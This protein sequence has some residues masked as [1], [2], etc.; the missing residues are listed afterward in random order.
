LKCP[1]ESLPGF[2]GLSGDLV[3]AARDN[4]GEHEI[5]WVQSIILDSVR[6]YG[7][8]QKTV[9]WAI[10]PHFA[11]RKRA[12]VGYSEK[13]QSPRLFLCIHHSYF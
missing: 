7:L 5:I 8:N 10:N 9:F 4:I 1:E 2:M 3:A 13:P 6:Y 12:K 11:M